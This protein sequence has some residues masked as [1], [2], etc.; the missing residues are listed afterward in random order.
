[1]LECKN[2]EKAGHRPGQDNYVSRLNEMSFARFINP[3]NKEEVL[4][5][6]DKA[7]KSRRNT[8]VPKR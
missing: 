3:E 6:M 4:D 1:M 7:F 2:E 5:E 8:R